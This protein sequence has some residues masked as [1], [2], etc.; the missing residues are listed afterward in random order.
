MGVSPIA[1]MAVIRSITLV[2]S[3]KKFLLVVRVVSEVSLVGGAFAARGRTLSDGQNNAPCSTTAVSGGS[4]TGCMVRV[5]KLKMLL[6]LSGAEVLVLGPGVTLGLDMGTT[7][8]FNLRGNIG[9]VGLFNSVPPLVVIAETAATASLGTFSPTSMNEG[10]TP[11]L[12]CSR[13]V[14]GLNNGAVV[15]QVY[16]L[17]RVE[18]GKMCVVAQDG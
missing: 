6:L 1:C 2:V 9:K 11:T 17:N 13:W 12:L 15:G 5:G 8:N 4:S 7:V 14:T 16:F 10:D 18:G 3:A